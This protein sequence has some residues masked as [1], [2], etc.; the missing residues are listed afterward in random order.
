[1]EEPEELILLEVEKQ[2]VADWR[3]EQD[4]LEDEDFAFFVVS[5]KEARYAGLA[6]AKAAN[7]RHRGSSRTSNAAAAAKAVVAYALPFPLEPR[8]SASQGS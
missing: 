4:L 2:R 8:P 1:M 3:E 7:L 5:W 6:V